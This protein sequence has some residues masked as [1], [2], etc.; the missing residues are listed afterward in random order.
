[1]KRLWESPVWSKVIAGIILALLGLIAKFVQERWPEKLDIPAAYFFVFLFVAATAGAM[2]T[3]LIK[4]PSKPSH[5]EEQ[6]DRLFE[7]ADS[8]NFYGQIA[9]HYD[10]RNTDELLQTHRTVVTEIKHFVAS[11]QNC[12]ILDVGGGTGRAIAELFFDYSGVKWVYVDACG[13]MAEKFHAHMD[14]APLRT[15]THIRTVDEVY[16]SL[17]EGSVDIII[18]SFLISSLPERPHFNKLRRL[19]STD[20]I[21]IVAD[22]DPAYVRLRPYYNFR[23]KGQKI[24]LK[25]NPIHYLELRH[26]CERGGLKELRVEPIWKRAVMYSYV[27]VFGN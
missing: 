27:A 24:A 19:L 25:T 14:G 9:D 16:E 12:V 3:L 6:F 15:E 23:L 17:H 20:G 2:S 13:A 7:T 8:V 26:L 11:K 22:A 4:R 1:M 10:E 21:L 5:T 18:M